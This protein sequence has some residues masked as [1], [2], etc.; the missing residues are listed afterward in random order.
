MSWRQDQVERAAW[1]MEDYLVQLGIGT[2]PD[3]PAGPTIEYARVLARAALC[4]RYDAVTRE[5][6]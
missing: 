2:D 1:R 5:K 4:D 3:D 6:T